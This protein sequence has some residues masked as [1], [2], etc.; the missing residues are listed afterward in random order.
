MLIERIIKLSALASKDQT[1]PN[2]N[3]VWL[4]CDTQRK[5]QGL[6]DLLL[7]VT[8]GHKA[9]REYIENSQALHF[10]GSFFFDHD[11]LKA[12]K[13]IAKQWKFT[14]LPVYYDTAQNTLVVGADIK[15]T[16]KRPEFK[17]PPFRQI[18][19]LQNAKNTKT[20]P[21]KI[22]DA[23]EDYIAE[24]PE[25]TVIGLNAKYLLEIAEALKDGK[26]PA[27]KLIIKDNFSPITVVVGQRDAVLMP[28]RV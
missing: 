25:C 10:E 13:P 4:S 20:V 21:A 14:E 19:T 27:V 12:L 2:L 22:R 28:C 26:N 8:D 5:A 7:E 9:S 3:G 24:I 16:V 1:R 11:L 17:A 18:Y 23:N 6:P 15:L